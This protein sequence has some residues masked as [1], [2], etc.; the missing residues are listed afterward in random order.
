MSS[1]VTNSNG[2]SSGRG[3]RILLS[4][5]TEPAVD[6]FQRTGWRQIKLTFYP[7]MF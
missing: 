7:H 3:K 2:N 5:A 4:T 1:Q 6:G